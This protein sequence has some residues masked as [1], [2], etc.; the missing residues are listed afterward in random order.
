MAMPI[1]RSTRSPEL[2]TAEFVRCNE[3]R[4]SA[5]TTVARRVR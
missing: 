3:I 5:A 2:K 1:W 4:H